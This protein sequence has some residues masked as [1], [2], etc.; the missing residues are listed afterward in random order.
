[1]SRVFALLAQNLR[2]NV[3]KS[4]TSWRSKPQLSSTNSALLLKPGI[5]K[6]CLKTKVTS[7]FIGSENEFLIRRKAPKPIEHH[8][9]IIRSN[10]LPQLYLHTY[11]AVSNMAKLRRSNVLFHPP[12]TSDHLSLDLVADNSA[13]PSTKSQSWT[14][15]KALHL[16]VLMHSQALLQQ[17]CCQLS[18]QSVT[19]TSQT[20]MTS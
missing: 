6:S 5:K 9:N 4:R 18:G 2:C 14:K 11:A 19:P 8:P 15:I 20:S 13:R 1:M 7:T 16:R 12:E 17:N 3:L 10:S